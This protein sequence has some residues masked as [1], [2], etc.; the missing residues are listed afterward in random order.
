M[1]LCCLVLFLTGCLFNRGT[2]SVP[3]GLVN[4]GTLCGP[5]SGGC[6]ACSSPD[7]A[8]CHDQW[9]STALRCTTNA[10]CGS[11]N[12]CQHD[13]CVKSDAD[14]DG[15]DD[16][17]EREVAQLNFPALYLAQGEPCGGPHG[18]IYRARRHP[19]HPSRIAI[20][21]VV[22]YSAD[23]GRTT[24]HVGDAETFAVTV[25]LDA[26]PGAPATV[27]VEAWAHA[28]TRCG[29]TSSCDCVAGT[30]ACRDASRGRASREV[31]LYSSSRK[32]AIY[33]TTGTCSENCFDSCSV[34]ERL[35]GPLLNVGEPD[36][37]LVSDL[38]NQGFVR[39]ADGWSSQLLHIN[40]WGST[41]FGGG[42]R[43]DR[44]LTKN[45]AP[46]GRPQISR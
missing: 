16:D 13:Y 10:H 25:D 46:S 37:P 34:G 28:R 24:G 39:A 35:T 32:H 22:L 36:H 3:G 7:G 31:V 9:Y 26:E 30:S 19:L 4:D 8:L 17:L 41:E 21:Y 12:G 38:T 6:P 14:G 1:R 18:V 42:G 20:T 23:C 2:A 40:P 45:V 11:S 44:P 29:S 5:A 43:L 15:L 33:L 27:G